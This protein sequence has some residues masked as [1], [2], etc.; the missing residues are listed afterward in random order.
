MTKFSIEHHQIIESA[1][2]NFNADFFC[3]HNILF[4]GGTRIALELDEFRTSIDIDFLCPNKESYRAVRG[5]VTNVSLGQLVLQQF[6]YPREITFSRDAVRTFILV[7]GSR[8]KLEFVC[9]DN[10]DLNSV[11]DGQFPVPY[12]DRESCFY[13]KLLAN[14]DRCLAPPYKD[15]FDIL[16]MCDNWGDIPDIAFEKAE[17]HYS[18]AVKRDLIKSIDDVLSR[19]EFYIDQA[20]SLTISEEYACKLV[21]VVAHGLHKAL[22]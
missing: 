8:I 4:G 10:Y 19:R 11:F 7:D 20:K 12:I 9:F 22:I 18:I 3:K 1:L 14:V 17:A 2:N 5:E 13:T 21:D 15:I 16:A 6:E